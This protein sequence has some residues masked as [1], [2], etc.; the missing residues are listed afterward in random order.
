MG[1]VYFLIAII[2]TTIG[3]GAGIGGGVIIKP[4]LDALGGYNIEVIGNLSSITI[5]SM[6]I[7]STVKCFFKGIKFDKRLIA[8]TIGAIVGGFL[9]KELFYFI[10]SL[11]DESL[12]AT[13]QAA[14]MIAL[15]FIA[16]F[17]NKLPKFHINN[18]FAVIFIG[19]VLGTLS[20]FLGIG[21]GP[22]N[23]AVLCMFFAMDIKKAA[24]GS[25]FII[26]CSQFTKLAT[27]TLTTGF[28]AFDYSML[29]FMIPGGILGGFIGSW[30]NT[31]F[32]KKHIE[33]L[34]VVVVVSMILLNVYNIISFNI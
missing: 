8:L 22:I 23:V 1:I 3:A 14:M 9:G 16:L 17:K 18:V 34:F 31:K 4:A 7:V 20:A 13:I 24:T 15:L 30:V 21:G 5:L 28:G 27:I 32:E 29:F 10:K 11:L 26:L 19:L 33:K 25:I 6:A 2:A 12:I